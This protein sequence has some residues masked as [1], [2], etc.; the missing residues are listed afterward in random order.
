MGAEKEATTTSEHP[1]N[2]I[3]MTYFMFWPLGQ[4]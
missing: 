3:P 1:V 4:A 2:T